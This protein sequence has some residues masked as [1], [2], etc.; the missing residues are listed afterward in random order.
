[1]E[2]KV[3]TIDRAFQLLEILSD[4]KYLSLKD[5]SNITNLNKTTAFRILQS[6]I[7]NGYVKKIK[8]N[9]YCLSLKTFKIG[10]KL[11]QNINF[12]PVAKRHITKL[13]NEINQIIHLVIIDNNEILYLDK[14]T[15]DDMSKHMRF[16]KVGKTAPI[17]CTAA[18]KAILSHYN[19]DDVYNIWNK[20]N[21]V[22]YTSRT[23]VNFETLMNDL[24]RIREN[25]YATEYEEY[26]LDT[27]CIGTSFYDTDKETLGAISISLP[28][29]EQKNKKFYVEKLIQCSKNISNDL[30]KL[31]EESEKK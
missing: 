1:M 5:I 10:N 20:I 13:A 2:D 31:K 25:K 30:N 23:I 7:T 27:F 14:Y 11:V 21:V 17:Y 29:S 18:G 6:L 8:K 15:P 12:L 28:L 9:K 24:K 16:S 19:E 26:E 3:Q 4:Y 22:K